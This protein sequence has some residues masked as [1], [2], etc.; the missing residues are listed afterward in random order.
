[1]FIPKTGSTF[2]SEGICKGFEPACLIVEVA[3]IIVHEADEPNPI[4]GL[5]DAGGLAGKE[6]TEIDLL[7]V[8]ADAAARGHGDGLVV[9]GIVEV[10]QPLILPRR[11]L[12]C[13]RRQLVPPKLRLEYRPGNR[14]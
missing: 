6:L 8:D 10:W 7:A 3:Q 1:M 11:R 12:T 14:Y 4:L 13:G 5:F 9:E 2:G